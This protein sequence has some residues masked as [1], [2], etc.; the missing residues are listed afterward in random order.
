MINCSVCLLLFRVCLIPFVSS[1]LPLLTHLHLSTSSALFSIFRLPPS[2]HLHASFH[3]HSLIS[4]IYPHLPVYPLPLCLLP[5]LSSPP[6]QFCPFNSFLPHLLSFSSPPIHLH[7]STYFLF[8]SFRILHSISYSPPP[9][10][11]PPLYLLPYP[12][13]HRSSTILL[14][15]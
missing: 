14:S 9:T 6:I 5:L 12:S 4:D 10:H 15:T 1:F 3:L 13:R 2:I 8:T 7:P 11:S